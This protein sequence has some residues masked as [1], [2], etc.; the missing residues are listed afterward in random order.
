MYRATYSTVECD[1]LTLCCCVSST[2]AVCFFMG[3]CPAI[4]RH[5]GGV[6]VHSVAGFASSDTATGM[7]IVDVLLAGVS[8]TLFDV[9]TSLSFLCS[10][11]TRV[12]G[13][14]QHV[15]RCRVWLRNKRGSMCYMLCLPLQ[16]IT[17]Q[18]LLH[19]SRLSTPFVAVG[20]APSAS[21]RG[22]QHTAPSTPNACHQ[23]VAVQIIQH[24]PMHSTSTQRCPHF[25]KQENTCIP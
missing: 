9:V 21:R 17:F 14:T 8:H 11:N 7:V 20:A 6:F 24:F 15:K 23:H 25:T 12:V 18:S 13:D 1:G 10:C 2:A 4:K 19:P 22:L 16:I 3:V 5:C